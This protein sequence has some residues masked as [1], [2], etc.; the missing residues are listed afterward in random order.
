MTRFTTIKKFSALSGYSEAAIR[1]KI[2]KG[3]WAKDQIW[4]RA[5]DGRVLI[6]V[7]GFNRWVVGQKS[8]RQT[9]RVS[10]GSSPIADESS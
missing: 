2:S 6:E 4:V 8:I 10:A 5:P 9:H 1:T 7:K 3:V